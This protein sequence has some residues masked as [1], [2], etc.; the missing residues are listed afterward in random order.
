MYLED[1]NIEE[2]DGVKAK[3][4]AIMGKKVCVR[5][6]L[7]AMADRIEYIDG[8]FYAI[9]HNPLNGADCTEELKEEDFNNHWY[10]FYRY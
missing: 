5:T 6:T 4:L 3:D 7:A 10:R 9:A 8:K 2:I 1:F